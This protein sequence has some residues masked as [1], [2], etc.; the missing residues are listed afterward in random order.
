[1]RIFVGRSSFRIWSA[2]RKKHSELRAH[3]AKNKR[4]DHIY[5]LQVLNVLYMVWY[6][7]LKGITLRWPARTSSNYD[8][9]NKFQRT[10]FVS[11]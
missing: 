4:G 11:E 1:M 2:T 6:I 3:M 5:L 7:L 9:R 10:F 8:I